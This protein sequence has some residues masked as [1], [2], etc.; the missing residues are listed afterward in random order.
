MLTGFDQKTA[1]HTYIQGSHLSLSFFVEK[2]S[3][4][5]NKDKMTDKFS[6]TIVNEKDCE[7]EKLFGL[8]FFQCCY[9]FAIIKRK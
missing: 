7:N 8:H 1:V 4:K 9:H 2:V 6:E 5:V 3:K